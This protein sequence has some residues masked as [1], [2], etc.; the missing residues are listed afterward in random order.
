M[1]G[2]VIG[3]SDLKTSLRFYKEFLNIHQDLYAI[4]K[5]MS[6]PFEN[7]DRRVNSAL[8]LKPMETKGAF[9]ELLGSIEIELIQATDMPGKKIFENRFWGDLG[10]I[11][12]CFDVLHMD[13]LKEK[14]SN[15][16]YSFTVDSSASF[17]METAAGRFCYTEDP[18]GTLIEL[19]ETHK[20]PILKKMGWFLDLQTRS[21]N[22]PL[23]ALM[24]RTMGL[25]KVHKKSVL[26]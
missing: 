24:I 26:I 12:L 11:H 21:N 3:V 13:A 2:A 14:A 16:G 5:T 8:L 22:K 20:I 6:A 18:D 23:P 17:N 19:V 4:E 1:C 25:N 7:T 15:F 9:S 10:F